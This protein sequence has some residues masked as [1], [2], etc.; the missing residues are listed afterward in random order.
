MIIYK[1]NEKMWTGLSD[2]LRNATDDEEYCLILH[3]HMSNLGPKN[4]A[5][6]FKI[7]FTMRKIVL[8]NS[9]QYI[10][11]WELEIFTAQD[12]TERMTHGEI[13]MQYYFLDKIRFDKNIKYS[14]SRYD[15]RK[16]IPDNMENIQIDDHSITEDN[17]NVTKMSYKD[18]MRKSR[19]EIIASNHENPSIDVLNSHKE[20]NE[21]TLSLINHKRELASKIIKNLFLREFN[22]LKDSASRT[23]V[24]QKWVNAV[25]S[26]IKKT[27]IAKEPFT[28]NHIEDLGTNFNP[29]MFFCQNMQKL[30]Q[31]DPAKDII[32][33][34]IENSGYR[35]HHPGENSSYVSSSAGSSS[36]EHELVMKK[37]G[38]NNTR[39][40][41]FMD[42]IIKTFKFVVLVW[43]ILAIYSQTTI[44]GRDIV[45]LDPTYN[46]K[47]GKVTVLF[48]SLILAQL[49]SIIRYTTP[50]DY[51]S[52]GNKEGVVQNIFGLM[53]TDGNIKATAVNQSQSDLGPVKIS[54]LTPA[55]IAL[56]KQIEA[57]QKA[58]L[59]LLVS[60][61][62]SIFNEMVSDGNHGFSSDPDSI[63][64]QLN[65][66]RL[67]R[68]NIYNV[69]KTSQ[70]FLRDLML[71]MRDDTLFIPDDILGTK[72]ELNKFQIAN[73]LLD[74]EERLNNLYADAS[75]IHSHILMIA[76]CLG[77][78]K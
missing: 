27:N 15:E 25:N 54:Y 47:L 32:L 2:K 8:A 21:A 11:Y 43:L 57:E 30:K 23:Q 1:D 42:N 38:I 45:I 72:L 3:R 36:K 71:D 75:G 73:F 49:H 52:M 6:V 18:L 9:V 51:Q 10:K 20:S 56:N 66:P 34:D 62:S 65:E 76:T 60:D 59:G 37:I 24:A 61:L 31:G 14:I 50:H 67:F 5:K 29:K 39:I 64:R 17:L 69:N 70:N 78:S 26:H 40:V 16:R 41:S 77:Y 46:D 58:I 33:N 4:I 13:E 12:V 74:M 28:D 19:I 44:V 7:N 55:E 53:D 48:S 35:I 22:P 68:D 63:D